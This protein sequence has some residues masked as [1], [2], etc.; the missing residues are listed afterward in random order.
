LGIR[1]RGGLSIFGSKNLSILKEQSAIPHSVDG[2][3]T[4]RIGGRPRRRR[5]KINDTLI[6]G[7]DHGGTKKGRGTRRAKFSCE[8]KTFRY[9]RFLTIP[10][11]FKRPKRGEPNVLGPVMEGRRNTKGRT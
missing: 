3:S 9:T 8:G 6:A 10:N 4:E 7:R 2:H 5:V 1:E 11:V